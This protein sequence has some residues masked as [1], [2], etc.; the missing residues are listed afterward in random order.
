MH[1]FSLLSAGEHSGPLNLAVAGVNLVSLS[2]LEVDVVP[3]GG[4]ELYL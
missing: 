1:F 3:G 4:A 2:W